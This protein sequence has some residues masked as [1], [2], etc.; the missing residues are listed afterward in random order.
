MSTDTTT[1]PE[2]ILADDQD[3]RFRFN[4]GAQVFVRG[5]PGAPVKITQRLLHL[6]VPGIYAPH[7]LAVDAE[8]KEWHSA[9]LERARTAADG[10]HFRG[11]TKMVSIGTLR[12]WNAP[13]PPWPSL[14]QSTTGKRP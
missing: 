2:L 9:L 1:A 4:V 10:D 3:T 8:G 14:N 7:Y 11:V 6:S 5:W 13:A 12:C